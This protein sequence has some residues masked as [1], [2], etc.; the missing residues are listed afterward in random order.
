MGHDQLVG[1][2]ALD[3]AR[4]ARRLVEE[5][6]VVEQSRLGGGELGALCR[7]VLACGEVVHPHLED[8]A[9]GGGLT[10]GGTSAS[11]WG[12]RA[13]RAGSSADGCGEPVDD[14]PEHQGVR[15]GDG[16]FPMVDLRGETIRVMSHRPEG[17]L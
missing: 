1:V 3:G 15:V 17:L 14:R 8:A 2:V 11:V 16:R 10:L 13:V 7:H 4:L 6:V 9:D 5:S 12:G